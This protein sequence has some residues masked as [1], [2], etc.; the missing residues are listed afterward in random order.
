MGIRDPSARLLVQ[1][2]VL[3]Q[4]HRGD[5]QEIGGRFSQRGVECE[6]THV[7]V[8]LP[9]PHAL[10]ERLLVEA[11]LC[12]RPRIS[13]RATCDGGV[14]RGSVAGQLV[15]RKQTRCHHEAVRFELLDELRIQNAHWLKLARVGQTLGFARD[16]LVAGGD[17]QVS[18]ILE[19]DVQTWHHE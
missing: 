17:A 2:L 8:G 12:E 13:G 6:W 9:Q 1:G 5:A 7:G 3:P 19:Y 16:R 11:L 10:K 14:D 18:Q 15:E 4:T